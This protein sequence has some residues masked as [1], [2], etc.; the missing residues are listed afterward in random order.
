MLSIPRPTSDIVPSAPVGLPRVPSPAG[1]EKAVHRS[2][3][4]EPFTLDTLPGLHEAR[5]WG[6]DLA[7]DILDYKAGVIGWE[8]V[9]V[10]LLLSGPPGV[11]KTS[12][13]RALAASCGVP[14]IETSFRE[15]MESGDRALGDVL[16][17]MSEVF[18]RARRLAPCIVFVDE[19]D[20]IP[21]REKLEARAREW[22]TAL[23]T[24]FLEHLGGSRPRDG[25]V[26]LGA[27][28]NADAIDAAVKRSGRLDRHIEIGLPDP[29]ALAD[30]YRF[31]LGG[32]LEGESLDRVAMLSAGLSGADVARIVREARRTAGRHRRAI[33]M[34]DLVAR[35]DMSQDVPPVALWR[36]SVHEAGHAVAAIQLDAARSVAVVLGRRG[37]QL[38]MTVSE[39][40]SHCTTR[41][42]I[43]T[44]IVV[45]LSG[46]AAEQVVLG[47][48]S[49]G[50][51]GGAGSD[52]ERAT[53]L[54]TSM[55]GELG[56]GPV[57]DEPV[58]I[59]DDM[60]AVIILNDV[61]GAEVRRILASA[62]D[63]AR[64][65]M[66]ANR[67]AV[68]AIAERL[69]AERFLDDG[70]LRGIL[71]SHSSPRPSQQK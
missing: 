58:Y 60:H 5:A 18:E 21:N 4:H 69:V 27:C 33:E 26:V 65:L 61:E 29:E 39:P 2:K 55:V 70:T 53:R 13:A 54:A 9:D 46:R 67:S 24:A 71:A 62:C 41:S 52:I 23:V 66:C 34:G 14:L 56:M 45:R 31:H 36:A 22:W 3:R 17:K 28:N 11:G 30:I 63:Q 37:N 64:R 47:D 48:F 25:V 43:E 40:K 50:S 59:S 6:K 57:E 68:V 12:Y 15:W 7:Q 10:G 19:L 16:A 44:S 32:E 49:A 1:G 42:A 38:G 35:L 8:D 51:G 20:A